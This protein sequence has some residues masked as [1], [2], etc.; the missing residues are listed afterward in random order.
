MKLLGAMLLLGSAGLL[1]RTEL[2]QRRRE[3]EA[4]RALAAALESLERGVR[5]SLAPLPCLMEQ[6]GEGIAGDFF[7]AV[8]SRA[9]EEPDVSLPA[10]W[11][12]ETHSLPL[13]P[14]ERECLARP[15]L[16]FGGEEEDLLRALRDCA[17]ELRASLA[18]RERAA[19]GESR[20]IATLSFSLSI[21]FAILL[22]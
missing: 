5:V 4:L 18:E 3:R 16:A 17:A 8:L 10:L 13:S 22:I 7:S 9:R 6:C 12:A 1:C 2:A 14:R 21:L 20:L 11:R 19:A 15:A